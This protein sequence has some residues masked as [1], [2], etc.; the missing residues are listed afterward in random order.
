MLAVPPDLARRYDD[1]LTQNGIASN[2]RSYYHKWLR[3][4]LDYCQKYSLQPSDP[5]SLQPFDEKLH[6]RNQA[7]FQRQQARHAVTLYHEILA[8]GEPRDSRR[9]LP[10]ATQAERQTQPASSDPAVSP[11]PPPTATL[12]TISP[13]TVAASV[14]IQPPITTPI[15]G[16]PN[17]TRSPL[18]DSL[19]SKEQP[20]AQRPSGSPTITGTPRPVNTKDSANTPD[21]P[22]IS[23]ASWVWVYDKLHMAIKVRHYSDKTWDAYKIWTNKFQ[24]YTRSKDAQLLNM[25]DVKGFLSHLAIDKKVSAS[26]QNQAFNALLFLFRHVLEKDFGRIEGVVRAKRRP[27]IPVVLSREEIDRIIQHLA[28]PYD[29]VAKLLYGCGL[30]LFE[31]LQLRIQDLNFE[32]KVLTVHDGKG[33]KDRTVPL[34]EVLVPE[35][36]AQLEK[37][38]RIHR[39]DL[40][41]NYAGTFLPGALEQKYKRASRELVWQWWFPAKML[42]LVA[43]TQEQRRYHLHETHVQ[44]AI[45]QAVRDS[46]IPKRASAHTFRHSFASHLLQANYDIR[47]IQEL[48]GHGDLKTTMIYTHTVRSVTLKEAKSPLDF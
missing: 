14:P 21:Q 38:M 26:S 48:L 31:C 22:K 17:R 11:P 43:Q 47:T 1:L 10:Q 32:M 29:L 7:D 13:A 23:G 5:R 46:Q 34:P 45:T 39:E 36:K 25:E 40:A 4:Y 30:R 15:Q 28:H 6:S 24:T 27:Y 37:V 9:M 8:V 16:H 42:T 20:A 2:Q 12:P 3:F 19:Q 44:K 33:Q 18:T 41:A 35:L